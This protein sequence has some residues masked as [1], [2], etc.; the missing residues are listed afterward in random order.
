MT[1][2]EI[3]TQFMDWLKRTWIG[4]PDS[5]FKEEAV[6]A[7]FTVDEAEFLTG[8]P[9]RRTPLEELATLKGM[10]EKELAEKLDPMAIKGLVWK[11]TKD[12]KVRYGLN[13]IFFSLYR[14]AFWRMLENDHMRAVSVPANQY[15]LNGMLEGFSK[16]E[17]QG[18]RTLPI[19]KT[20]EAGTTVRPY[21]D[22][23]KLL[24]SFKYYTVSACP[25]RQRKNLDP[26][27]ENSKKPLEVCLHFDDLGH[28]IVDNEMGREITRE[29]T[30]AILLKSAKAGLVHGMSAWQ[31]RPDT[32]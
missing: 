31:E 9:F 12:G 20:I 1:E 18:L 7:R 23:V 6:R 27:V 17:H 22:V 28:Y 32:I 24:D 16:T 4:L 2:Q 14:S 10:S 25:C 30:E 13:E 15:M 21:E 11:G 8:F 19:D 29:E 3:Y 5:E 26:T